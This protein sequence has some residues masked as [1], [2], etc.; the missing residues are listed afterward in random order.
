MFVGNPLMQG[1]MQ[2]MFNP[3]MYMQQQFQQANTDYTPPLANALVRL[4]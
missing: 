2:M 1:F 4:N 3:Q